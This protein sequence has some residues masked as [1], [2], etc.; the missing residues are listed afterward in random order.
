MNLYT[1]SDNT[2]Y[3]VQ[4]LDDILL[5]KTITESAQM[6]STAIHCNDKI[7]V[8]PEGIYKKFNA[9]EEHNVWVRE[10]K[11]NYSW[12]FHYL[13]DGL[14]E[15]SYRFGKPHDT[16]N[17]AGIF[18]QYESAFEQGDMTPFP[19]KFV[20]SLENYDYLMNIKDT[21]KAY[22]EYLNTKW[23]LKLQE[24]KTVSWTKRDRPEFYKG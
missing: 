16:W 9:N 11:T 6:L 4:S 18:S 20:K 7:K 19:R 5:G 2:K 12:T 22:R 10:N 17:V 3:C 23:R 24:N 21:C 14:N 13:L 1:V 8:K 15:F